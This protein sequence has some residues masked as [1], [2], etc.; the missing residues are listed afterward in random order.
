MTSGLGGGEE[1]SRGPRAGQGRGTVIEQAVDRAIG[2]D[3]SRHCYAEVFNGDS[4]GDGGSGFR[5][6]SSCQFFQPGAQVPQLPKSKREIW[7]TAICQSILL[8]SP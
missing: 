2:S 1:V 8:I 7:A 6:G 5:A 3:F 4:A